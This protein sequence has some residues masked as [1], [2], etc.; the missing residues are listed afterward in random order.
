MPGVFEE[1]DAEQSG[2]GSDLEG[3]KKGK[4]WG[5][6]QILSGRWLFMGAK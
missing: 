1:Q 2:E 3:D 5:G 6:Q 4:G